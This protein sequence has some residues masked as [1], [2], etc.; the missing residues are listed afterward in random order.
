MCRFVWTASSLW[1][2]VRR[3]CRFPVLPGT[4]RC[5]AHREDEDDGARIPC[6]L[7]PNHTVFERRLKQHLKAGCLGA[8]FS[9]CG[10]WF[11][12]HLF[13]FAGFYGKPKKILC[14]F[15]RGTKRKSTKGGGGFQKKK[16]LFEARARFPT[17]KTAS[18]KKA[19]LRHES[20]PWQMGQP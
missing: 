17:G 10:V 20:R 2:W 5:G 19:A 6:P 13:F 12:E 18:N 11:G 9:N 4:A 8:S 14:G 7:D 3:R 16:T 15:L 1:L